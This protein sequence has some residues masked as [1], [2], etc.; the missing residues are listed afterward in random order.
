M[1]YEAVRLFAERAVFAQPRFALTEQ[2]APAVAEVC[3]RRDGILLAIELAAARVMG[4]G[5]H[6]EP[7]ACRRLWPGGGGAGKRGTGRASHPRS[8]ASICGRRLRLVAHLKGCEPGGF[9]RIREG[10]PHGPRGPRPLRW[11]RFLLMYLKPE[12]RK[13]LQNLA[14]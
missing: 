2:N 7:Q 14:P 11:N 6:I 12:P 9:F 1:E 13:L 3:H 8:S 4:G 5:S 10:E